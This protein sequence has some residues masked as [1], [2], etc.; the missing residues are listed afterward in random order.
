MSGIALA[1]LRRPKLLHVSVQESLKSYIADNHLAPGAP[2]PAESEL[3]QQLG[4]SRSS[5]REAIR[6]LESLGIV[7]SR[8]GVGVFV[9][10][11]SLA[12]LLDNLVFGLR[13]AARGIAEVLQIRRAL[14]MAL[15][16]DVAQKA[17]DEDF[18]ALRR[19]TK[20]MHA[21][22]LRGESFAEEDQAFHQAMFAC[23]GN[24]TLL[25]L[26]D[27]FWIAFFKAS[28]DLT[29][30]NADPL[31]TWRDHDAIVDALVARDPAEARARLDQ[32]YDGITRLLARNRAAAAEN[33]T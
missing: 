4:V 26:M 32:H 22:A 9:A 18:A 25:H 31:A 21:R 8:R 19:I 1:P 6:A 16:G 27:V 23:L 15:I 24:A 7:E 12:P 3:A 2:L 30:V 11:F 10:R 5:V 28:D 20:R 17:S 29:L 13:A 14:E 33:Q